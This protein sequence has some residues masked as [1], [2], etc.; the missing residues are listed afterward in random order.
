MILIANQIFP[1]MQSFGYPNFKL[2]S[3]TRGHCR[4]PDYPKSGTRL[5][6]VPDPALS[7]R[8]EEHLPDSESALYQAVV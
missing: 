4:I 8:V 2:S 1:T 6:E 3:G 5:L 7:F